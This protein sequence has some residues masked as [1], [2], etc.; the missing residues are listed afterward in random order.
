M[1]ANQLEDRT[2]E[3]APTA[4]KTAV[5][6]AVGEPPAQSTADIPGYG[7]PP[8]ASI[9]LIAYT[10][11]AKEWLAKLVELDPQR[12]DGINVAILQQLLEAEIRGLAEQT[13]GRP[14]PGSVAELLVELAN[15]L[16][17]GALAA[18][19]E[20]L[21]EETLEYE[22]ETGEDLPDSGNDS[23][24]AGS[25]LSSGTSI[26]SEPS[27]QS[28]G[29]T[30]SD[31]LGGLGLG[32]GSIAAS[33]DSGGV[34][35]SAPSDSGSA[36]IPEVHG[37]PLPAADTGASDEDTV[38]NVGAPGVLAN[39]SDPENDI[40]TVTAFDAVSAKGAAVTVNA[41]GSYS[42]DPTGSG[43]LNALSTGETTTDTFTY[44]VSD[45]TDGSN[46]ATVTITVTGVNDAPVAFANS[47]SSNEDTVLNVG[48]SGV[49]ANDTDRENDTLT[50]SAFDAVS[51]KGAA[52]TVNADGS[53]SYDP[54]GSATLGALA[55]GENTTDTFTYT[56]SDS[57]G[58]SD[59]ATVTITVTGVN[60][61][62]TAFADTAT[63]AV[64]TAVI[65]DVLANDSDPDTTD[66]LSVSAVTQATSGT[67][68]DN[69]DGTVT[70]TPDGG[71]IGLDSFT[72]DISDGNGGGDTATVSVTVGNVIAGTVGANTLIGTS[73]DDAIYG[74]GGDDTLT[75]AGGAD[76]FYF[77]LASDEGSD[78]IS[79]F[80]TTAGDIFSFT[81]V[82]DV[83]PAAGVDI[84]DVVSS[85]FDGGG[86]GLVDT[87]VL[88]SGTTILITDV[89]GTLSDLSDLDANSLINGI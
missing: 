77:S 35:Y 13:A 46:T 38:L 61:A 48:A 87:V 24:P 30:T 11:A 74:Y 86:A 8:P 71:F 22:G 69:G 31:T 27:D 64:D 40:L 10:E 9:G 36:T 84:D 82:T 58:G 32:F 57:N 5:Q 33:E 15:A 54:T 83:K 6:L 52:V 60:D 53:Y 29:S 56:V 75:G 42:Y 55:A 23:G 2:V 80:S 79:D 12:F 76:V 4:P 34:A 3:K 78:S 19:L 67:V 41:D 20:G 81:D 59:T 70:Y 1:P 63:T 25:V 68:V 39:D 7:D 51:A 45:G 49:L 28:F 18:A 50:V 47:E 88:E 89:D 85:F 37:A 65:E 72:Y 26:Y 62:P 66:T 44:T 43:T 17:D 16:G 73:G 21:V 14:E